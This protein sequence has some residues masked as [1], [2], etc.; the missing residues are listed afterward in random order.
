MEAED[1]K[2]ELRSNANYNNS[3]LL[4]ETLPFDRD[5]TSNE[6]SGKRFKFWVT[7]A[8]LK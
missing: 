4:D 1:S 7:M 8:K 3:V 2:F 5:C 6:Q